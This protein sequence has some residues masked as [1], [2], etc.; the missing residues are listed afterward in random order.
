[1]K[2]QEQILRIKGMLGLL[3][4]NDDKHIIAYKGVKQDF[5]EDKEGPMFFTKFYDGARHYAI[6]MDGKVLKVKLKFKNPLIVNAYGV[7]DSGYGNGIPIYAN[8]ED[9]STFIGTFSDYDIN[10]KISGLGYDGLIINKKYGDHI[11]GWE[12]LSF[13]K[14]TREFIDI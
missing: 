1:M 14:N 9:K 12:I 3:T 2:L 7:A 6:V 4:E 11:D 10:D 13:S 8:E 5:D